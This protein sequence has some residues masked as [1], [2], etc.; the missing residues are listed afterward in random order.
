[1]E[2]VKLGLFEI[3]RQKINVRMDNR[4]IKDSRGNTLIE[5]LI[6]TVIVGLVLTAVAMT[7]MYS[8][9]REALNR[10]REYSAQ[11]ASE[12]LEFLNFRRA[13]MGWQAFR[14]Y[15]SSSN[16]S[17]STWCFY[18][19]ETVDDEPTLESGSCASSRVASRFNVGF[20]SEVKIVRDSPS[21]ITAT[22]E[23]TGQSGSPEKWFTY[24]VQRYFLER[25][26]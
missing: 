10:Y 5:L 1:M 9:E 18:A 3:N 14:D 15:Y 11:L 20:L 16:P 12:S 24:E 23:V 19:G 25:E 13:S 2:V 4:M 6:A 7:M 8:I 21:K 22:V 17:S 26:Y